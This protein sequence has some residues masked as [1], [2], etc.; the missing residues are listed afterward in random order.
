[1]PLSEIAR[2]RPFS[3]SNTSLSDPWLADAPLKGIAK[4]DR[5]EFCRNF[6][7]K[8]LTPRSLPKS[9]G[10]LP[11]APLDT[12]A[13]FPT[14]KSQ[15][16]WV[17]ILNNSKNGKQELVSPVSAASFIGQKSSA[18]TLNCPRTLDATIACATRDHYASSA[19]SGI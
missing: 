2:L 8:K 14:W 9:N 3:G 12:L 17:S 11:F 6:R 18:F 1:M 7:R 13:A 19:R 5:G 15:R 16:G 10:L 4:E